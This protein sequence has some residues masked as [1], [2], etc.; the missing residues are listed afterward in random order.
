MVEKYLEYAKFVLREY[1]DKVSVK[2]FIGEHRQLKKSTSLPLYTVFAAY[3]ACQLQ[4][5]CI[6]S[7]TNFAVRRRTFSD[8]VSEKC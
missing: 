6:Y 4:M 8:S 1:G 7:E 5:L 2:K 3:L